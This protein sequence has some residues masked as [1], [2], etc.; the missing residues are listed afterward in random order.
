MWFPKSPPPPS[1]LRKLNLDVFRFYK[2]KKNIVGIH[3]NI[4]V[5]LCTVASVRD[6]PKLKFLAEAEQNETLGRNTEHSM[7]SPL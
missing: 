2:K 3:C 5:E 1:L 4:F 6:A 7:F